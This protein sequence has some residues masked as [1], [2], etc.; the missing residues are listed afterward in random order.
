MYLKKIKIDI[1]D[2]KEVVG[3]E[4][5]GKFGKERGYVYGRDVAIIICYSVCFNIIDSFILKD[6]VMWGF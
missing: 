6:L 3:K 2:L 4:I 5:M 1:A